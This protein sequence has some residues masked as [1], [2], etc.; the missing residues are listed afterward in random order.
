MVDYNVIDMIDFSI[1]I[2][3]CDDVDDVMDFLESRE[4]TI[5][6]LEG[7]DT[8]LFLFYYETN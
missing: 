8:P 3:C 4:E 6:N 1:L 7:V 2:E 5:A